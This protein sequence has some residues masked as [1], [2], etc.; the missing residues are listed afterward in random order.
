MQSIFINFNITIIQKGKN[1]GI[2]I[3]KI[4]CK[5]IRDDGRMQ[6][7]L[8]MNEIVCSDDQIQLQLVVNINLTKQ[9]LKW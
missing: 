4:K 6:W 1:N 8:E 3:V 2:E 7:G 5:M 9:V